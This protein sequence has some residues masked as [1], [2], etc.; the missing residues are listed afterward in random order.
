MSAT[1]GGRG[2]S[3]AERPIWQLSKYP[4]EMNKRIDKMK[5]FKDAATFFFFFVDGYILPILSRPCSCVD[6]DLNS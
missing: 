1:E 4:L 2:G 3:V 6:P 5:F